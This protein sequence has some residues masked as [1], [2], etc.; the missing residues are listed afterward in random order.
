LFDPECDLPRIAFVILP[1][2]VYRFASLCAARVSIGR[3]ALSTLPVRFLGQ[4]V[5]PAGVDPTIVEIEERTHRD[6]EVDRFVI[7]TCGPKRLQIFGRDIRGVVIHLADETEQ[8][9]VFLIDR[10]VLQIAEDAPDEILATQKFRRNCGV[11]L[12]SKRTV[13]PVRRVS[14]DQLANARADRSGPAQNLLRE[15]G[16]MLR[17]FR[18]ECEKMPDLR[19]FGPAFPH[20]LNHGG[21][22]RGLRIRLYFREEHRVHSGSAFDVSVAHFGFP[23]HS[24]RPIEMLQ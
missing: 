18:V 1:L 19:I 21:V 24:R 5:H 7:P 11:G 16:E 15:A 3:G 9:L 2:R 17:G 6:G 10:R 8:R 14:G 13:V 12:Y 23:T 4:G 20:R 22:G